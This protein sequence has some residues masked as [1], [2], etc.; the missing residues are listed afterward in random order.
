MALPSINPW[1]L[2]SV[3]LGSISF[4]TQRNQFSKFGL[5]L[6]PKSRTGLMKV[7]LSLH[8]FLNI[9]NIWVQLSNKSNSVLFSHSYLIC[10][11]FSLLSL[12]C[13]DY[14]IMPFFL[15]YKLLNNF[16]FFSSRSVWWIFYKF[17]CLQKIQDYCF[18]VFLS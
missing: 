7:R 4:N 12:D 9:I 15:N 3:A 2:E 10:P 8:R 17:T 5:N 13:S 18:T 1:T 11:H 16:R 6:R 14:L